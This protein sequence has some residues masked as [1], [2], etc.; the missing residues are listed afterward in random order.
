[1]KDKKKPFECERMSQDF[2]QI[3]VPGGESFQDRQ[4]DIVRRRNAQQIL[5]D[6]VKKPSDMCKEVLGGS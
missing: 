2:M 3:F 1:M 6:P 5:N 4:A